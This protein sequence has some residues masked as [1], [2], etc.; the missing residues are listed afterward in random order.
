[1]TF[2]LGNPPGGALTAADVVAA[3][4]IP[5]VKVSEGASDD[6][7]VYMTVAEA[8]LAFGAQPPTI[9]QSKNG[10]KARDDDD[11]TIVLDAAPTVGNLLVV[12]VSGYPGASTGRIITTYTGF[13]ELYYQNLMNNQGIQV[14]DRVV[15][16]G[17]T[18][19]IT[20][21]AGANKT[22]N[23]AVVEFSNVGGINVTGQTSQS[24]GVT[25]N[26]IIP[27]LHGVPALIYGIFEVDTTVTVS[28]ITSGWESVYNFQS[29]TINHC[30]ALIRYSSATGRSGSA[31][32]DAFGV[33]FSSNITAGFVE[34]TV[35]L[36]GG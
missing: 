19:T 7:N 6:G 36:Y 3:D 8:R 23:I 34:A 15:Q 31:W 2:T 29:D 21:T 12:F 16:S 33:T 14:L 26:G 30:G 4:R 28:S 22:A 18:A 17:D 13:T 32:I 1:M 27:T 24:G 11:Q 25:V 35:V 20:L 10:T 9:V 5:M